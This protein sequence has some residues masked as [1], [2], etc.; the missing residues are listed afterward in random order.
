MCEKLW[1][2]RCLC[3][4]QEMAKRFAGDGDS[5]SVIFQMIETITPLGEKKVTLKGLGLL[6]GMLEH[7]YHRYI[8]ASPL[9][10]VLEALSKDLPDG[11]GLKLVS[12]F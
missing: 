1:F 12:E 4:Q 2:S 7:Q 5:G 10:V 9:Q 3:I 11:S 6:F 8:M